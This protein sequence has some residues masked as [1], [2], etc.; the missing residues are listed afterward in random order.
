MSRPRRCRL[1][2]STPICQRFGPLGAEPSG[3]AIELGFD[4]FESIRLADVEGMDL[5]DVAKMMEVSRATAGRIVMAARSKMATAIVEGRELT[6]I[7]GNY[8]L[9]ETGTT[10]CTACGESW[11][12]GTGIAGP[13]LCP[14]CHQLQQYKAGSHVNELC[15]CPYRGKRKCCSEDPTAEKCDLEGTE[16]CP[17]ANKAR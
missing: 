14:H 17:K 6:I 2:W 11:S 12:V 16:S 5:E 4:E 8:V 1:I 3:K 7:G 13:L 9:A 15:R 10:V